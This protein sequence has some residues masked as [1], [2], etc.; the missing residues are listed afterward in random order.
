MPTLKYDGVT[1][2]YEEHGKGFPILTFAPAGL[3]STISVWSSPSAPINPSTVLSGSACP[4]LAGNDEAHPYPI[5]DETARLLPNAEFIPEWKSGA[6][7]EAAKARAK[8]FIVKH[9]PA[10][11]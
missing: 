4:V 11:S 7:L 2:Y 1:I 5:S 9:T 6:P 8:Q 10:A 3:Q